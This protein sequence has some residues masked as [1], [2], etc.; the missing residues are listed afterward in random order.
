MSNNKLSCFPQRQFGDQFLKYLS[1]LSTYIIIYKYA[2]L[3]RGQPPRS[4]SFLR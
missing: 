2:N 4:D 1:P 3:P